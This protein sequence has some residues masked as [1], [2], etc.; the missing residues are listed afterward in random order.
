MTTTMRTEITKHQLITHTP[1]ACAF[2][3]SQSHQEVNDVYPFSS[4]RVVAKSRET[5]QSQ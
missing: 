5:K 2:I 3:D 4:H 1:F